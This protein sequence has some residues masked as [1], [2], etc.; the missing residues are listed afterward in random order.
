MKAFFVL[1]L[2]LCTLTSFA[3]EGGHGEVA[4]GGKFGGITAPLVDK[5]DAGK[6]TKAK[7]LYKAELVRA[8]SGKLS[9]YVFDE[10]MELLDL[11][12]FGESVDAKLEVKKKG[13]FIYVGEFKFTK[14]GSH[15]TAQLP[16]VQYKPFNIDL[17]LTREGRSLFAGFSNL[18]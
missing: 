9:L 4:E 16:K 2:F 8:E 10:K 17:F 14:N 1:A 3:H 12:A 5:A 15:Y 13:K 18:D 11:K 6:G 7:T